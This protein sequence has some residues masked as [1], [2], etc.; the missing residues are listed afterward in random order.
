MVLG[1]VCVPPAAGA[2][3][4][5]GPVPG[6]RGERSRGSGA[7]TAPRG[8]WRHPEDRIARMD[9][10]IASGRMRIA[11]RDTAAAAGRSPG[12]DHLGRAVRDRAR[13]PCRP[14][15]DAGLLQARIE[16]VDRAD[17]PP[18]AVDQHV[19]D[20]VAGGLVRIAGHHRLGV[21]ARCVAQRL[22]AADAVHAVSGALADHRER[23][24]GRRGR[25]AHIHEGHHHREPVR[26]T[27]G[28]RVV[29]ARVLDLGGAGAAGRRASGGEAAQGEHGERG[30]GSELRLDALPDGRLVRRWR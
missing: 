29:T 21:I 2:F 19:A 28:H 30:T 13:Q 17:E 18:G 8:R 6:L 14:G 3:A 4:T 9:R 27:D 5:E 10:I 23:L 22:A 26:L 11:R 16:A 24:A 20:V 1:V 12:V 15:V 7:C 25:R